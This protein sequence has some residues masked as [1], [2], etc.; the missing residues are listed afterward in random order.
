METVTG[1]PNQSKCRAVE[2]STTP[3]STAQGSLQK[4][5]QREPE[6]V[7][8]RNVRG[9]ARPKKSHKHGCLSKT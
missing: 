3:E 1:N 4:K 9:G 6:V 2:L 5:S 7:S 8:P